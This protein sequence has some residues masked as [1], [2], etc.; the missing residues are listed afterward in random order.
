MSFWHVIVADYLTSLAKTFGDVQVR[1]R[2]RLRLRLRL[3]VRVG[4]GVRASA[5]EPARATEWMAPMR[6]HASMA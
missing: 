5:E 4:V 6:A 1:V 3:R 2:V